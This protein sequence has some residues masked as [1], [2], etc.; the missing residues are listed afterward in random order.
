MFSKFLLIT[1][2]VI[3]TQ[4]NQAQ[5]VT[6]E[7]SSNLVTPTTAST[8]CG[9]IEF[10]F[11]QL[12]PLINSCP[13]KHFC[14]NSSSVIDPNVG[15]CYK[16]HEFCATLNQNCCSDTDCCRPTSESN[17]PLDCV[18]NICRVLLL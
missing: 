18:D 2:I 5:E 13:E 12:Y 11:C 9:T 3:Y 1:I 4:C 7:G 14:H 15:I 16:T 10:Q 17:S 6:S 8:T